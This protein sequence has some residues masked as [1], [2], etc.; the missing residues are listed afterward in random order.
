MKIVPSKIKFVEMLAVVCLAYGAGLPAYAGK[1]EE[2]VDTLVNFTGKNGAQPQ[3]ILEDSGGNFYGTTLSGGA[4]NKGIVFEIEQSGKLDTLVDFNGANGSDPEAG[5]LLGPDGSLYGTT[6]TGGKGDKGTLFKIAPNGKFSTL[7][8]FTGIN[9]S[10]PD[11]GLFIGPDGKIYGATQTGGADDKGTVFKVTTTGILV[12]VVTFDGKNGANP[13]SL[14]S[15]DNGY[16]FGTC[17]QSDSGKGT[18]FKVGPDGKLITLVTFT[19]AN[20]A[21]PVSGIIRADD[22]NFYGTT[23][24]G[25]KGNL[26]TIYKVTPEGVLTTVVFFDGINGSHPNS[27]L[28]EWVNGYFY[29]TS[30]WKNMLVKSAG[31]QWSGDNFC[32]T[33]SNGGA[34]G[35][36]TVFKAGSDGTLVT[37][38]EFTGSQGLNLGSS[39]NSLVAGEDG[40]LYGTTGFGGINSQGTVF[41]LQLQL[42]LPPNG[43]ESDGGQDGGYIGFLPIVS[44]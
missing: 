14:A 11:S 33:T 12:V 4:F 36:G 37:L 42:W 29:M 20:G 19:G 17:R 26:G 22:G 44:H 41:R 8:H 5:L 39:P 15:G 13:G 10:Q 43:G 6:K 31:V 9:G 28:V 21:S 40:N 7:V 16:Y 24:D 23:T 38:V 27:G 2:G 3:S 32:G 34:H 18:I 35:N 1:A 25:G 30:L